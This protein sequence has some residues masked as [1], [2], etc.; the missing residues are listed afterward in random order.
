MLIIIGLGLHDEKDITLRGLELARSCD[1]LYAEFYTSILGGTFLE[2]ISALIGKEIKLLDRKDLEEN[3]DNSILKDARSKKVGLLVAGDPLI[4]TTHV[5]VRLQANELGIET[6]VVHNASIY[7]A[8][9]S[10]SGLQNYKFGKS[11]S[12]PFPEEGYIPETPYD[13]IKE[14]TARGLHTLLF[15][16][17]KV[18][19]GHRLMPAN[20][21]ID[22]LLNIEEKRREGIITKETLCVVLG[23]VG[24]L[25]CVLRAGKVKELMDQDFGPA[26]HSLIVL[27]K[28]HFIEEEYLRE[29]AG[30]GAR[31]D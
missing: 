7:S 29:F 15:L 28:L 20:E 3:A 27:G 13:V 11:A 30:L 24:S 26:P 23:N 4:S 14:N 9:A 25:D 22:I 1:E 10:I 17:I 12:I 6:R 8:S 19:E 18:E 31:R 2:K 16:D 21:A 5:Q